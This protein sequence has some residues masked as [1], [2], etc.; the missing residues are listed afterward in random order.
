MKV[1]YLVTKSEAGGAQ[2]HIR[3]LSSY[4]IKGKNGVAVMSYPGGW[5]EKEAK[6]LGVKFYPNYFLTNSLNLFKGYRAQKKIMGAVEDFR[7][8]LISCHSSVAGFLGRLSVANKFPVIF[9][10]HGWGFT[11]GV[12]LIRKFLLIF[13]E[14]F[15]ARYCKRIICVSEFDRKIALKHH[16]APSSKLVTIHNGAEIKDISKKNSIHSPIRIIFIGRLAK[17]KDPILLLEA[18]NDLSQ[19]LKN[20]AE[21]SII[22][23][24]PK[25]KEIINFIKRN[26]L[27]KQITLMNQLSREKTFQLLNESDLFV[28]TSNWEGLPR[29]ILEAMS[30][31]LAI[32]A[33][34]VGGVSEIV[35]EGCGILVK[36]G[37]RKEVED[38]LE[39]MLK[40][41]NLILQMGE[42]GYEKVRN[43]FSLHKMLKETVTVYREV[44]R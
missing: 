39:K 41:P 26:K 34:D 27:S 6:D 33:S 38:A 15:V 32:I 2:T 16:I 17:Q 36:A 35:D 10:A 22:G 28:L 12:P 4:L 40:N 21:I 7:P 14:K 42:N 8:D 29:S 19:D 24:G 20:K 3:Q 9:T 44:V 18:F 25:R 30:F 43:K 37:V 23:D 1:F 13:A 5:L 31:R 11:S